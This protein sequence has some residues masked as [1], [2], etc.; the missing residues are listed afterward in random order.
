MLDG[1]LQL[2]GTAGLASAMTDSP[3]TGTQQSTNVLDLLNARD[4]G[5]G[6]DPSLELLIQIMTTFA[7]GTSLQ[8]QLQGAPDNGSGSP[9]TYTTM[10][11][12]G[13]IAEASLVA[14]RYIL[15]TTVP[16]ILL[17]TPTGP[18]AAQALP[19]FLRLQYITVGTHTAGALAGFIVLDRQDQISYPAG[20]TIAN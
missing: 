13:A 14:G 7:S 9:G 4:L 11:D 2:T 15:A 8:V 10:L 20:I 16:R 17:P 18:T 6:D 12:S 3:T 1:L 5:I 19:R